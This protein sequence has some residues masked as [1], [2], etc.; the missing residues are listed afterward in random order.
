MKRLRK[1]AIKYKRTPGWRSSV[2]RHV[3]ESFEGISM[4]SAIG[5]R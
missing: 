5:G 4:R 2:A 3:I 1:D